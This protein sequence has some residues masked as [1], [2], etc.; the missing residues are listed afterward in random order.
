MDSVCEKRGRG[1]KSVCGQAHSAC[2]VM[3]LPGIEVPH[4]PF[5]S[6]VSP[7]YGG[8]RSTLLR[9][10]KPKSSHKI[11]DRYFLLGTD[12]SAEYLVRYLSGPRL[13]QAGDV[14]WT[15]PLPM[16][17]S[18]TRQERGRGWGQR[19]GWVFPFWVQVESHCKFLPSSLASMRASAK[20]SIH[21]LWRNMPIISS[22]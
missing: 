18:C 16:N 12:H 6:T 19:S 21:I 22:L 13:F 2:P 3:H 14:A 10:D 11:R 15:N 20:R 17:Y 8:L 1:R 5:A 9:S 4:W 7:N